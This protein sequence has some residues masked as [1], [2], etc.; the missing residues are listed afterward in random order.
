MNN[1]SKKCFN[2]NS[3]EKEVC[4]N[5]TVKINRQYEKK[6]ISRKRRALEKLLKK[7]VD[8]EQVK[9]NF[10]WKFQA[11]I[12]SINLKELKK[13]K[14]VDVPLN[15]FYCHMHMIGN[16][17]LRYLKKRNFEKV[18]DI[19]LEHAQLVKNLNELTWRVAHVWQ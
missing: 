16:I 1:I 3:I 19:L 17:S 11:E 13:K 2:N 15:R 18:L 10:C 14:H 6:K 5:R 7:G 9:K 12:F 4:P 8:I